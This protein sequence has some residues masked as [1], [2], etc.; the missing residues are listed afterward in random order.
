MLTPSD[1][2]IQMMLRHA[3]RD[4]LGWMWVFGVLFSLNLMAILMFGTPMHA[5]GMAVSAHLFFINVKAA[6]KIKE[7]LHASDQGP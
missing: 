3:Y 4:C 2:Y 5:I 1:E 6:I 7:H